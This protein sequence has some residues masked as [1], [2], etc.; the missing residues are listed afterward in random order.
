LY[1]KEEKIEDPAVLEQVRA[2]E[3]QVQFKALLA[4]IPMTLIALALPIL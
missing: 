3:S 2:Q 4:A 1:D